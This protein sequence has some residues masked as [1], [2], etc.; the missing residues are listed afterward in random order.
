M[1][2]VRL[3]DVS[4]DFPI[5]SASSRMLVNEMLVTSTGGRI[6]KKAGRISVQALDHVS[7]DVEHGDR[8]ALIGNNGAGK[9][10]ML[11][12]MAGIYEPTSG[13]VDIEGR[14]VPLFD[15]GLGID[16]ESTGM[17]NIQLR[18]LYLGLSKAQI[19][20]KTPEIAE[21]TELGA[22]LDMPLR[23]YSAGMVTRLAFA[24][25]TCIEPDILLLDEGIGTGDAPFL[26]KARRRL[27]AF[28]E[29]A[30]ILVLASHSDHVVRRMCNKAVLL[31][32]GRIVAAGGVDEVMARY[33]H[34][35]AELAR[36]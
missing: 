6:G 24:I 25:S 11:R 20:E 9:S 19:R 31:E 17:E 15:I 23:T 1:V 36:G 12:V 32:H 16:P 34:A 27:D 5:Y 35:N 14:P 4:V 26:E 2:H 10:T 13:Q 29:R 33:A 21:F 22:F 28:V 8:L 30:G 18:G 7:L 3:E